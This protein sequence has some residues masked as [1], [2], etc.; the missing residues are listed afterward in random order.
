[1]KTHITVETRLRWQALC[2][3]HPQPC[4]SR[5]L[6]RPASSGAG[7]LRVPKVGPR[8]KEPQLLKKWVS[9]SFLRRGVL[10]GRGWAGRPF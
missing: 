6:D 7:G 3:L 2:P 10:W 4:D 9:F 5:Q 1:M 8:G